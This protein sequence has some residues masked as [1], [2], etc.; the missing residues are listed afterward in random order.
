MF[1]P[2]GAHLEYPEVEV[3]H[4]EAGDAEGAKGRVDDV[5]RV[6]K[7]ALKR[8]LLPTFAVLSQKSSEAGS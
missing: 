2:H 4:D 3:H 5:I 7:G 6:V 1:P 8:F